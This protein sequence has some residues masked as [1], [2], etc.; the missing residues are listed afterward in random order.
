M[1]MDSLIIKSNI[2]VRPKWY[3]YLMAINAALGSFFFG[4]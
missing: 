4:F 2:E 3:I 1:N